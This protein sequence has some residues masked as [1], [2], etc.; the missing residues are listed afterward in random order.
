M[1]KKAVCL[2]LMFSFVLMTASACFCASLESSQKQTVIS[3]GHDCC[4]QSSKNNCNHCELQ[5]LNYPA[6]LIKTA[7]GSEV[8]F[9]K[10]A[11]EFQEAYDQ[12]FSLSGT[13]GA[14]SHSIAFGQIAVSPPLFLLNSVLII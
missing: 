11:P 10:A 4:P 2:V 5:K 7:S 14:K 1:L 8:Y 13:D 9:G 12:D 3:E 6:E